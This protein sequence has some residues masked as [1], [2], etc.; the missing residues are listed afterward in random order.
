MATSLAKKTV[1]MVVAAAAV[2]IDPLLQK[3][4]APLVEQGNVLAA[5]VAQLRAQIAAPQP[6]TPPAVPDA[7]PAS[8]PAPASGCVVTVTSPTGAA[9]RWD[10]TAA[11]K[12]DSLGLRTMTEVPAEIVGCTSLRLVADLGPGWA[13]VVPRNDIA[14]RAG[15]GVARYSIQVELDGAV[16]LSERDIVHTQYRGQRPYRLGKLPAW[17]LPSTDSLIRQGLV[18]RYKQAPVS[19]DKLAGWAKVMADPDWQVRDSSRGIEPNMP[20]TGGRD[21]IGPATA[22]QAAYLQA[23]DPAVLDYIVGQAEAATTIPWSIWDAKAGSWLSVENW[24]RLWTDGR[25][26][27]PGKGTLL[28]P[29]D[30]GWWKPENAHQPDPSFVPYLLTGERWM[31]DNLQA[32]AAWNILVQWPDTRAPSDMN[33]VYGNQL[34]GGAWA[35]RQ[36]DEAAWASPAGSPEKAYFS[37][38]SAANWSWLVSMIPSWSKEQGEVQGWVPGVYGTNGAVGPWQQDY[39]ASTTLAAARRGNADALTVLRWTRNFL[40]GRFAKLGHDGCAYL[41]EAYS[42]DTGVSYDTWD[43][44][45]AGT[46]ARGWSNDTGWAKSDGNYPQWARFTLLGLAEVLGDA[47]AGQWAARLVAE[48]APYVDDAAFAKDPLLR[49]VAL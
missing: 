45:K 42:P 40:V 4:M 12:A 39:F 2:A 11:A 20:G 30:N 18:A 27:E 41:L 10:A 9:W 14:M 35:L 46:K 36:I 28:Q 29:I 15:G 25:G 38:A 1:D 49:V 43:K 5:E 24:P 21:D 47:E 23:R 31:L 48:K 19:A 7:P 32:Q 8:D 13:V 33:V 16:V 6:S 26:G 44:V 3:A 34:R 22:A 17:P 37:K